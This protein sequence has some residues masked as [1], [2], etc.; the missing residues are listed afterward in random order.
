MT[1]IYNTGELTLKQHDLA[2]S[3]EW[4]LSDGVHTCSLGFLPEESDLEGIW[5]DYLQVKEDSE[6]VDEFMNMDTVEN[7]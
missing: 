7:Y 4:R 5:E 2:T 1:T 3:T 6:L